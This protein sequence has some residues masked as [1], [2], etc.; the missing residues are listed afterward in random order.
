MQ[1][2]SFSRSLSGA[3]AAHVAFWAG[4]TLFLILIWAALAWLGHEAVVYFS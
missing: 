3:R 4:L 2:T 1:E